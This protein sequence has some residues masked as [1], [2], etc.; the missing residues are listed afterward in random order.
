MRDTHVQQTA[1]AVT[2]PET[3]WFQSWGWRT[4]MQEEATQKLR[5]M[6]VIWTNVPYWEVSMTER[7]ANTAWFR[8]HG[9]LLLSELLSLNY[10]VTANKNVKKRLFLFY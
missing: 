2:F 4:S 10:P 8:K 3:G 6:T 1:K 9:V 5:I 7:R